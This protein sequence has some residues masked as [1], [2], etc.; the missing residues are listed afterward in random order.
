MRTEAPTVNV[1]GEGSNVTIFCAG[2]LDLSN[3]Q[4]FE[5]ELKQA[6]EAADRVMVDFTEAVFIDTAIV[7]LL[8][9]AAVGMRRRQAVLAVRLKRKSH[10]DHV[11]EVL[12]FKDIMEVE[13]TAGD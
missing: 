11:I 1:V 8:A 12:G 2:L 13:V 10:P 7:Q 9:S 6:A 5:R 3:C 4:E